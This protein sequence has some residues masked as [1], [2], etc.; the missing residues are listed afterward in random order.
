M[1][2]SRV[3]VRF[4]VMSVIL[5]AILVSSSKF[6]S[7]YGQ[8]Y[9]NITS[10]RVTGA[11]DYNAPGN[12]TFWNTIDWTNVPLA[13][14]VSP[15]GGHTSEVSI[16]S[17]NDGFNIYILLK[18]T[19]KV[20]PSFGTDSEVYSAPNGTLIPLSADVTGNVTQLFHNS[21]YYYPDRVAVL[22]FIDGNRQQSPAM[23]LG[24][25]GAI[26]GGA[27][28]I[29]H[30]QST[31]TDNNPNDSA[32]PG[33]YT[34]PAGNAIYPNDNMSFAEDD[35][36]NM[37]GFFVTAGNF[38]AGAPNLDP[39]ADP[40]FIHVGNA[41]SDFNK[42]WSVEMVRSFA[43]SDPMHQVQLKTGATYYTAFAVWNGLLGES[44]HIKSV[45]QWFTITVSDSPPPYLS[46][47]LTGQTPAVAPTLA[48]AVGL[49]LLITGIIIGIAVRSKNKG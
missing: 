5:L 6:S 16:K 18:W 39:Y 24:S 42:T 2:R 36:T 21:T 33:G 43:T 8:S 3:R 7:A 29:W 22:W 28:D 19:D 12:E 9:P 17:A 41:F 25:N 23:E 1:S 37:T 47:T 46:T 4:A 44:A 27:A 15:G 38:G 11:P 48:A 10:Y 14:S 35:F 13:A 34:D 26:T 20:G 40:F 45:S 31:P 30:W 32:F 49:G